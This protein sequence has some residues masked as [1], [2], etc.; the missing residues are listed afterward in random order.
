MSRAPML[1]SEMKQLQLSQ[2]LKSVWVPTLDEEEDESG[3]RESRRRRRRRRKRAS[4]AKGGKASSK[5]GSKRPTGASVAR[6]RAGAARRGGRSGLP[7]RSNATMRG[8]AVAAADS[9][10]QKQRKK[11][12]GPR[13]LPSPPRK[14]PPATLSPG[15]VAEEPGKLPVWQLK[16]REALRGTRSSERFRALLA[17]ARWPRPEAIQPS[18]SVSQLAGFR[19]P[20]HLEDAPLAH[21]ERLGSSASAPSLRLRAPPSRETIRNRKYRR[22]TEQ[23]RAVLAEKS[24][25]LRLR[26]LALA[27]E[28]ALRRLRI[29]C[30][31]ELPGDRT[32]QAAMTGDSVPSP[33]RVASSGG[34]S[35][36]GDERQPLPSASQQE[37][38]LRAALIGLVDTTLELVEAAR[39][40]ENDPAASGEQPTQLEWHTSDWQGD[41]FAK[42]ASGADTNFLVGVPEVCKLLSVVPAALLCNPLLTAG[43]LL[44][45]AKIEA[46]LKP[47][48]SDGGGTANHRQVGSTQ[49]PR[50]PERPVKLIV[51]PAPAAE[52]S[53]ADEERREAVEA[54]HAEAARTAA[55]LEAE[56]WLRKRYVAHIQLGGGL[57]AGVAESQR[58]VVRIDATGK[59]SDGLQSHKVRTEH[60]LHIYEQE[61]R[62]RSEAATTSRSSRSSRRR[63]GKQRSRSGLKRPKLTLPPSTFGAGHGEDPL[64]QFREISHRR[65]TKA[66]RQ[67]QRR[68]L[69]A[70]KL[71]RRRPSSAARLAIARS[72]PSLSD[73]VASDQRTRLIADLTPVALTTDADLMY[74]GSPDVAEVSAPWKLAPKRGMM[75]P[76]PHSA[77]PAR[78]RLPPISPDEGRGRRRR[79]AS[80][81]YARQ[82]HSTSPTSVIADEGS[83]LSRPRLD[84]VEKVAETLTESPLAPSPVINIAALPPF[85]DQTKH[86]ENDDPVFEH[87]PALSVAS[88]SAC[89]SARSHELVESSSM[90]IETTEDIDAGVV[91]DTD[92]SSESSDFGTTRAEWIRRRSASATWRRPQSAARRPESAA[93]RRPAS[94]APRHR[95]PAAFPV[96]SEDPVPDPVTSETDNSRPGREVYSDDDADVD[97][98]EQSYAAAMEA[99]AARAANV[100]ERTARAVPGTVSPSQSTQSHGA[101]DG[102]YGARVRD[103]GDATR[104]SLEKLANAAL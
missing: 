74:G 83:P 76:R 40:V 11:D 61:A 81:S 49:A 3:L 73:R 1:N 77:A 57:G 10:P 63:R 41:Y 33:L 43:G 45:P 20:E 58:P 46:T 103:Q 68:E 8:T 23:I 42:I 62:Q 55:T 34:H 36:I 37:D 2:S 99:I 12:F 30:Q 60:A 28:A 75:L 31:R 92:T 32:L 16:Y 18:A 15:L 9:G 19:G 50:S 26:D 67:A 54:E 82:R 27:R 4:G 70:L 79:P 71:I 21:T 53:A 35:P 65:A 48:D 104:N 84:V 72:E 14:K 98:A 39:A 47:G 25:H 56:E 96:H 101:N 52:P 24:R 51:V 29:A 91:E 89:G 94:A 64:K 6:N 88:G 93:R 5:R 80:A 102:G 13:P 44:A 38:E 17:S 97:D 100:E 90:P 66:Q 86:L 87:P 22:E 69:R 59:D 85:E 78:R 95:L 7:P